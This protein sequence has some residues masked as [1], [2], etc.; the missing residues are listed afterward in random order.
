MKD[1]VAAIFGPMSGL[2]SAHV[3][4]IC[5]AMEIPHV[6]TRWDF[7]ENIDFYSVNLYPFYRPLSMA[8]IN[9]I[10]KWDWTAFTIL[11]ETNEG[12]SAGWCVHLG[13]LV[14]IWDYE[15][16]SWTQSCVIPM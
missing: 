4:S 2:S 9:I 7:R 5:D 11:Y 10:E 3:Q 8:Y 14:G 15:D 13:V 12:G 16:S 1:G 6:E